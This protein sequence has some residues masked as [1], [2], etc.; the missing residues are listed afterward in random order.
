MNYPANAS[1]G[2]F[3]CPS[4]NS[5]LESVE[6]LLLEAAEDGEYCILPG[7]IL[8][9]SETTPLTFSFLD[10]QACVTVETTSCPTAGTGDVDFDGTR[11]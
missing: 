11:I 2:S 5:Q 4:M 7:T 9:D 3:F 10:G 6:L 8:F 1:I